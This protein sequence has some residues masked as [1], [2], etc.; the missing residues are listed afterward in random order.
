[1]VVGTKEADQRVEVVEVTLGLGV[2][3]LLVN[4]FHLRI[5]QNSL[6]QE[7]LD[8]SLVSDKPTILLI[9]VVDDPD[10]LFIKLICILH[11]TMLGNHRNVSHLEPQEVQHSEDLHLCIL[12]L[13]QLAIF[14]SIGLGCPFFKGVINAW[15]LVFFLVNRIERQAVKDPVSFSG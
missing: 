2:G 15:S 3:K 1:M 14:E 9:E 10:R 12:L 5:D 13:Q 8:L 11:L 4:H 7:L 6:V